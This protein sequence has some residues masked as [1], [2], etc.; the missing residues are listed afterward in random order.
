MR[1]RSLA[2]EQN[3]C[4]SFIRHG[5]GA[6]VT[7]SMSVLTDP[8]TYGLLNSELTNC[9]RTAAVLVV[10]PVI[11]RPSCSA[12]AHICDAQKMQGRKGIEGEFHGMVI[13]SA[14]Y[15]HQ[16]KVIDE[17]QKTFVVREMIA[18]DIKREFLT[19]QRKTRRNSGKVGDHHQRNDRRRRTSTDGSVE[20]RYAQCE[21]GTE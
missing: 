7:E 6:R 2:Q 15:E 1:P 12:S 14:Q 17:A 11:E 16:F 8:A 5:S 20:C 9:P 10:L 3:N 18:E 13:E 19:G 4:Q 21:N